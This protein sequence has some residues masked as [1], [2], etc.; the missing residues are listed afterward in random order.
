M[1]D[2]KTKWSANRSTTSFSTPAA[3]DFTFAQE[4]WWWDDREPENA[5]GFFGSGDG[6]ADQKG[7]LAIKAGQVE[8][9]GEKPY[10]YTVEA[11]VEDVNRQAVA[12]R[13]EVTV[14][15]AGFYVGLRSTS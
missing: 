4:T 10:T 8:A 2:A 7:D 9:P 5:S 11:E 14:H 3:P 12:G 6:R 15:P 13:A 1:S